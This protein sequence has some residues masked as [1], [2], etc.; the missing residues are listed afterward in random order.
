MTKQDAAVLIDQL[1]M[2]FDIVRLVDVNKTLVLSSDSGG[3]LVAGEDHC[4][5]VWNK[6][7]RCDNCI[8]AQAFANRDSMTKFEFVD[9]DI[10]YV[11]AKYMEIDGAHCVL[12]MVSKVTDKTLIGAFGKN[13]FV[14]T[15]STY[16][17]KLYTDPVTGAHNR[18]YFD[19]QLLGLASVEA[20]A[21]IDVDNFKEVNDTYGHM[22]GDLSL[23][24]VVHAVSAC[25]RDPDKII[26]YGGDE[27]VLVFGDISRQSLSERL[28]Q[29]RQGVSEIVIEEE[30]GLRLSVSI[31]AVCRPLPAADALKE[32][33]Q[34]LYLAKEEKN[35]VRLN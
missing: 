23:R 8:S 27:F 20:L 5:A 24:A 34:M 18:Y 31:G 15:I 19:E 4:Y 30:P 12:E 29:I 1:K 6:G 26:R 16:N 28:E 2:V 33:D 22:V 21:M 14:E 13:Q 9:D 35:S 11:I 10:Y 25:L 17:R 3:E 7:G 32:A